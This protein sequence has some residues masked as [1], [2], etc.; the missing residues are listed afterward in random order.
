M[1]AYIA[2]PMPLVTEA[3][4]G[5]HCESQVLG[6]GTVLGRGC[7]NNATQSHFDTYLNGQ[8]VKKILIESFLV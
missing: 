5:I 7:Y 2:V 1:R 8:M 3:I 4:I 6:S